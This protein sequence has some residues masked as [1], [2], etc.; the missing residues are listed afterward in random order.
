MSAYN[1]RGKRPGKRGFDGYEDDFEDMEVRLFFSVVFF[2][3][4]SGSFFFF[5]K[6]PW[7]HY[8]IYFRSV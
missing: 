2:V 1:T 4:D 6:P 7:I 3:S 5:P 8:S